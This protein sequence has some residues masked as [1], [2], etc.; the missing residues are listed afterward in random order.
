MSARPLIAVHGFMYDPADKGGSNDPA[1]FFDYMAGISGCEVIGFAWYSAPFGL[2]I[3]RPFHSVYQTARAWLTSW[4]TG[5]LHPYRLAWDL[6][7][8][9]AADLVVKVQNTP[10]VVDL[11]AHSLGSRVV[12]LA[13][14]ALPK[15]KVGRVV[16]FNGAEL[17]RNA[18]AYAPRLDATVLNLAVQG[19]RVLQHLGANFSGDGDGWCIGTVGLQQRRPT[20]RDVFLDDKR[21]E[22]VAKVR[23]GWTVRG[24][25]PND[26]LDHDA[27]YRFP[28]NADLVR[29]FLA[30]DNLDDLA[31]AW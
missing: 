25:A 15:G 11:V 18:R 26:F 8:K 27:S 6:A 23:R 29:A 12:L 10:G 4:L 22:S 13:M 24:V 30:G 21:V 31:A 3:A 5:H 2:R 14:L 28:G 19:D 16:I 17:A 9:A 20:W 7:S 1:P